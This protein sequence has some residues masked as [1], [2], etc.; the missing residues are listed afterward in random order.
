MRILYEPGLDPGN[1]VGSRSM[2]ARWMLVFALLLAGCDACARGP[3]PETI[4]SSRPVPAQEKSVERTVP[5]SDLKARELT[6]SYDRTP[7]G[8]MRVV[9]WIPPLPSPDTKLPVLVALHG[10]GESIK[11]PEL[12]ARGW[13]DDYWLPRADQR[14]RKPPLKRD[15]FLGMVTSGRLERLNES[16]AT[17]PY[18]GVIVVCPFTPDILG[19]KREF[20]QADGF[21]R[22][23]VDDLLPRVYRET[24]ALGTPESTGID[25][26]SL[27]GR[28]SLLAGFGRPE[29]FGAV[30]A[31]QAAFRP[32]EVSNL[33][34]VAER[35]KTKSE[36]RV[37]L[38][39][40][41]QD[42]FLGVTRVMS[43]GLRKVG[44][45]HQLDIV[46]GD[47]SYEFNRGP[48]VYE[49]LLWHDRALRGEPFLGAVAEAPVDA[50]AEA[51]AGETTRTRP[52][53]SARPAR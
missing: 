32:G 3:A 34:S 39:S 9:V 48:G 35:A 14:L 26:V 43:A 44:V 10:R 45:E 13:V 2:R 17:R 16:L 22:F 11:G 29:A 7:A 52:F 53:P 27:G 23:V 50:G 30:G 42:Y 24:P 18:R 47:H 37:R 6:W 4:G 28:V 12:G 41:D 51:D 20:S 31:L 38:L 46:R 40:S 1:R 8:P 15:D 19:G 25:G 5:T 33:L 49:M 36:Q 21:V